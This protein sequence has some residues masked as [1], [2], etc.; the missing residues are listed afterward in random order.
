MAKNFPGDRGRVLGLLKSLFGLSAALVAQF[1]LSFFKPDAVAL[2]AFL[3]F[4]LSGLGFL[5]FLFVDVVPAEEATPLGRSGL[6]R[7]NFATT[8]IF[9][10]AVFL[11]VTAILQSQWLLHGSESLAEMS[12]AKAF[13]YVLIGMVAL[14]LLIAVNTR[15]W[16]AGSKDEPAEAYLLDYRN[17]SEGGPVPGSTPDVSFASTMKDANLYIVFLAIM[18]GTGAGLSASPAAPHLLPSACGCRWLRSADSLW[19]FGMLHRSGHQQPRRDDRIAW[20]NQGQ[21]GR[22]RHAPQRL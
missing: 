8:V 13:S 21:P 10:L 18:C 4:Y 3:A 2:L 15:L 7:T 19:L 1:Y 20:G 14:N 5:G 12:A 17:S 6:R 22:L 16:G 9:V 11:S